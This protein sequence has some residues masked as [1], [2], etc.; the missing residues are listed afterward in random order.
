[1]IFNGDIIEV[2]SPHR[3]VV[4]QQQEDSGLLI[5]SPKTEEGS[6]ARCGFC[7]AKKAEVTVA[8]GSGACTES[9]KNMEESRGGV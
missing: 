8:S 9:D 7:L 6:H 4:V 2:G 3:V 1:M 5:G